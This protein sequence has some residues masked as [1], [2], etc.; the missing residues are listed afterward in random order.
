MSANWLCT[1]LTYGCVDPL[2]SNY[3]SYSGVV[4][5][6]TMCQYGG[7]NDTDAKNFDSAVRGSMIR[8]EG[9]AAG[10]GVPQ[11]SKHDQFPCAGDVQ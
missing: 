2:A 3:L 8:A 4:S 5:I 1:Y 6:D 11:Y 7:C 10:R 9:Y